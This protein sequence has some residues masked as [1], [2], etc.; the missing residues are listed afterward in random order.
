[1]HARLLRL[2]VT[3]ITALHYGNSPLKCAQQYK[4]R[5]LSCAS[6]T[7]SIWLALPYHNA[8]TLRNGAFCHYRRFRRRVQQ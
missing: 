7:S 8:L 4:A 6:W 1:M 2:F 5:M 3:H